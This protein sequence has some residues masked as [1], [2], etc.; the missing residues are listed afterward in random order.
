MPKATTIEQYLDQCQAWRLAN[1]PDNLVTLTIVWGGPGTLP[2]VASS[3]PYASA[4][5]MLLTALDETKRCLKE[6][7]IELPEVMGD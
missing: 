2:G 1:E 4:L 7:G 3:A 6:Q 5:V